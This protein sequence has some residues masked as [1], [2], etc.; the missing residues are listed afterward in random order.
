MPIDFSVSSSGRIA[1]C[2]VSRDDV[3]VD[4]ESVRLDIQWEPV[5]RQFFSAA[6]RDAIQRLGPRAFFVAWTLKEAL[7]KARGTTLSR[8]LHGLDV[9]RAL[10]DGRASY[11]GLTVQTIGLGQAFAGAVAARAPNVSI[12]T[13]EWTPS[14][15]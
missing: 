1:V 12:R 2:A 8:C 4:V 5:A 13:C 6:E 9:T 10:Q 14:M 11:G 15:R 7:I 3:G